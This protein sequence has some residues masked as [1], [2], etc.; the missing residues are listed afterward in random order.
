[1]ADSRHGGT[2]E[3]AVGWYSNVQHGDQTS[4]AQGNEKRQ[5][6]VRSASV[7]MATEVKSEGSGITSKQWRSVC[8]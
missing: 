3:A 5:R 6:A 1:M 7:R 8:R 4:K 2:K